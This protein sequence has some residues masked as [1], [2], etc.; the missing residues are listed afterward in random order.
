[1]VADDELD[2]AAVASLAGEILADTPRLEAM[3]RASL[4]LARP[5]AAERIAGEL[6]G[7]I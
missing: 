1:V 2:P 3:S 5:D 4:S 6:L 7:A